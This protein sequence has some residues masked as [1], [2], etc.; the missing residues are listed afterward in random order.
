M[1]PYTI[2]FNPLESIDAPVTHHNNNKKPIK[3]SQPEISAFDFVALDAS[4]SITSANVA[5]LHLR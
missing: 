5:L 2:D 1:G 4:Q 3:I